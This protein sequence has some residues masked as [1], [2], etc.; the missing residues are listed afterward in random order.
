MCGRARRGQ[1]DYFAYLIKDGKKRRSPSRG[2]NC[3]E[4]AAGPSN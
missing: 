3:D 2:K 4:Y 1:R